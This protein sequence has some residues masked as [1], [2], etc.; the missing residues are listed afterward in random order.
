[1]LR[2][3]VHAARITRAP[4]HS[5]CAMCFGGTTVFGWNFRGKRHTERHVR[6]Y[7]FQTHAHSSPLPRQRWISFVPKA[8]GSHQDGLGALAPGRT[9]RERSAEDPP[10]FGRV[11]GGKFGHGP[12]IT[13]VTQMGFPEAIP[14]S[15]SYGFLFDVRSESGN[16]RR[17]S[18]QGP[19]CTMT[20]LYRDPHIREYLVSIA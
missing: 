4:I 1:M 2:R 15:F 5:V 3:L 7:F 12:S 18:L 17:R 10:P 11:S 16:A 19:I 6:A 14:V 13:G 20:V 9:A 8:A